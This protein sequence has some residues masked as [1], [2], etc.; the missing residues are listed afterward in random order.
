M[1][2]SLR[3]GEHGFVSA[4]RRLI[5]PLN[6]AFEPLGRRYNA[7]VARPLISE[8][9]IYA[10]ALELL[11]TEGATALTAR[12]L[13]SDLK[14]STRT[15]YQQVGTRD[16]LIRALVA[17]HFSVLGVEFSRRR[18]WEATALHW[19]IALRETLCAHPFLTALMNIDDREA[20]EGYVSALL[21]SMLDDGFPRELATDCCRSLVNVTVNHA[22]IEVSA[23]R[24]AQDSAVTA[25]AIETFTKNFPTTIKWILSGVRADA[26]ASPVPLRLTN[27]QN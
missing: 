10:R 11:D 3:G 15:L 18:T 23:M 25:A 9:V 27:I 19:C 7:A 16:Q 21:T 8:D 13:A 26:E 17:R 20:V 2:E 14:I 22:I 1:I 4:H 6:G 5:R 12:R 24:E